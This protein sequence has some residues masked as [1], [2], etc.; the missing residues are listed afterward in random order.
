MNNRWKQIRKEKIKII[1]DYHHKKII[2][3]III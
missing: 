3:I 1:K 2:R